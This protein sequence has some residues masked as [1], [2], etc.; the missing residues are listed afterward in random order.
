MVLHDRATR[1]STRYG[2]QM[3]HSEEERRGGWA[4]YT[5]GPRSVSLRF[6]QSHTLLSCPQVRY[7]GGSPSDK[8][9]F[10]SDKIDHNRDHP[11]LS[12]ISLKTDRFDWIHSQPPPSALTETGMEVRI[13]VRHRMTPCDALL[14]VDSSLS[15]GD[16]Y[17]SPSY[18]SPT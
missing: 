15:Q 9:D 11:M 17:V 10:V 5:S 16:R 18:L 2:W 1:S 8:V 7:K 6:S 14:K 4:R 13:Q 3:V 12:C